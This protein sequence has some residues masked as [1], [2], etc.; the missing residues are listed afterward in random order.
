M[1][2]FLRERL[3][4]RLTLYTAPLLIG[5]GVSGVGDLGVPT[6]AEAL[7]FEHVHRR[8][9]QGDLVF[10]G[11]RLGWFQEVSAAVKEEHHV[12]GTC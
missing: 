9:L 8:E 6:I 5:A 10:E 2:T 11:Y 7:R 12:Y 4:D 3:F 1:T